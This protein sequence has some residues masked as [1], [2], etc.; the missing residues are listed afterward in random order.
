[1][2]LGLVIWWVSNEVGKQIAMEYESSL[3]INIF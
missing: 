1:M 3:E 2:H